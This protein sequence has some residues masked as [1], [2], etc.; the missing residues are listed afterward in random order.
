MVSWKLIVY[1]V[2]AAGA[3]L[4]VMSFILDYLGRALKLA[5]GV[6]SELIER[7]GVALTLANFVMEMIFYVAIPTMAY[8][9]FYFVIPLYGVRAGMAAALLGF[10]LGAVPTVMSLSLRLKLPA[11]YLLYILLSVLI[12][13][14]GSLSIIAYLYSL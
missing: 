10:G 6:P 11:P 12:K 2:V 13:L 8:S 5:R 7:G 14:G 1:C 3:Y 4:L 9:F